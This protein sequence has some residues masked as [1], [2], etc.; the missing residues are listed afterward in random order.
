MDGTTSTYGG[1]ERCILG[2]RKKPE[3]NILLG[4]PKHGWEDNMNM[5]LHTVGWG[6]MDWIHLAQDRDGWRTLVNAEMNL[7]VP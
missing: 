6:N 5:D 3:G 4:R 7:R 1:E 2:L